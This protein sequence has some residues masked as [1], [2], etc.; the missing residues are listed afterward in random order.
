MRRRRA[1]AK[2][3]LRHLL[4]VVAG[5]ICFALVFRYTGDAELL[6]AISSGLVA[7]AVSYLAASVSIAMYRNR[8]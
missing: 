3:G 5:L 7:S 4:A 8:G 1:A 2:P 6:I